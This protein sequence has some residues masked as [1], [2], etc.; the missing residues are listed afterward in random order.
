[1]NHQ[2]RK[3]KEKTQSSMKHHPKTM[4]ERNKP[5]RI[6]NCI[7]NFIKRFWLYNL[8]KQKG[9]GRLQK[10]IKGGEAET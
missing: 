4:Q 3:Q 10:Q 9:T 7:I 5:I 6:K 8:E 1:M 2:Q